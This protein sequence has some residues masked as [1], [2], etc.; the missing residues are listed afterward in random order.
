MIEKFAIGAKHWPGISKLIEE[1]GEAQQVC[2]KLL[3]TDGEEE[4]WDGSNLR[5]R[6]EDELADLQAAIDF[7]I[8]K[9][10]LDSSRV[11]AR[12]IAKQMTFNVW[13][14]DELAK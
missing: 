14:T 12:V 4:H 9:N 2:G 5:I 6:L 3:G 11:H 1:M 8:I 10:H 13:H 7:V